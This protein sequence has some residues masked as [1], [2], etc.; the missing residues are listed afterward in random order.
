M[1][2]NLT[3]CGKSI[4]ILSQFTLIIQIKKANSYLLKE[5]CQFR[6]AKN[7]VVVSIKLRKLSTKKRKSTTFVVIK[8]LIHLIKSGSIKFQ[9]ISTC[10]VMSHETVF[11]IPHIDVNCLLIKSLYFLTQMCYLWII[12]IQ[13]IEM[14][15]TVL[16]RWW[17]S[18]F[19]FDENIHISMK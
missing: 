8:K 13:Y 18:S 12:A 17:P 2:Q 7:N 5:V 16:L 19:R 6:W 1:N 11:T 14:V 9:N 4:K 10:E 15:S 3:K